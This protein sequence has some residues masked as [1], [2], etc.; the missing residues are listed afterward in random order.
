M[1][2]RGLELRLEVLAARI[3]L[4][5]DKA[6]RATGIEKIALHGRIRQLEQ[7]YLDLQS[8]LAEL[9]RGG[10][11]LRQ[12]LKRE[13]AKL[14]YDFSGALDDLFFRIDAGYRPDR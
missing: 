5:H 3:R 9:K 7:R 14:S 2:Q 12:G 13:L 4:L 6:A 10:S 8:R 11:G 1:I